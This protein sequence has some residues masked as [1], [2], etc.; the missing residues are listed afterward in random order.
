MPKEVKHN[1]CDKIESPD[2]ADRSRQSEVIRQCLGS[3]FNNLIPRQIMDVRGS[4]YTPVLASCCKTIG[5][6]SSI[7]N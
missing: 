3:I 2:T 7:V 1:I 6:V 5:D 4:T